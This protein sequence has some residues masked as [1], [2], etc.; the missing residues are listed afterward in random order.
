[1]RKGVIAQNPAADVAKPKMSEKLPAFVSEEKID[2]ILDSSPVSDD[3]V[4]LRDDVVLELFYAAG[5]RI[6]EL[7]NLRYDDVNF[8]RRQIKVLGK[9]NKERLIPMTDTIQR[10]LEDYLR[11]KEQFFPEP[12]NPYL[13][14]NSKGTK[15]NEQ[16]VYRCV[17]NRLQM[18]GVTGK[19]SP[20]VLRHTFATHLMNKGADLNSIKELLGHSSL[21]ATQ[22]YTH[23][24]FEKLKEIHNQAHP[25]A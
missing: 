22:I 13:F 9:R 4:S 25:R 10:T 19:C 1:M 7:V 6:S 20:H 8:A 11:R 12:Q 2:R 3:Y 16:A 24:T 18:N 14:L 5:L 15:V 17:R 23:N 21:A